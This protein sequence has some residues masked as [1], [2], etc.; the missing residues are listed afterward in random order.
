MYNC[1]KKTE[2]ATKIKRLSK[3]RRMFKKKEKNKEKKDY[4][5]NKIKKKKKACRKISLNRK[6]I[7]REG[8]CRKENKISK[9]ILKIY[10]KR[11]GAKKKK[12]SKYI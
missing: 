4:L 7:E 8:I 12:E 10:E 1:R 9:R 2:K 5:K 11:K 6:E 3:V